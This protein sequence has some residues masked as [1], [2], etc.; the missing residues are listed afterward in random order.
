MAMTPEQKEESLLRKRAYKARCKEFETEIER[1][2]DIVANGELAQEERE[3]SH[4]FDKILESRNNERDAINK[5]IS[6]LQDQLLQ[7]NCTYEPL[8]ESAKQR[9]GNAFGALRTETNRQTSD[10]ASRYPDLDGDAKYYFS[11]WE[12]PEGYIE[13][14]TQEQE[15]EEVKKTRMKG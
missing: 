13:R 7:V 8:I 3:A 15:N 12:A 4:C 14:F 11:K 5:K 1:V 10:V 9:R 2:S 6:E